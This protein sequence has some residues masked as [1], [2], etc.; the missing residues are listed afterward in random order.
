SNTATT[1][2]RSLPVCTARPRSPISSRIAAWVCGSCSPISGFRC[3]L[4]RS[5]TVRSYTSRASA[6]SEEKVAVT[7]AVS[8]C[9]PAAPNP[10][11]QPAHV[12]AFTDVRASRKPGPAHLPAGDDERRKG[13]P[14]T[15][16]LRSRVENQVGCAAAIGLRQRRTGL[17]DVEPRIRG[18]LAA[19]PDVDVVLY[20]VQTG[21]RP[22]IGNCSTASHS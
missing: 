7:D 5:R 1:D 11:A 19:V 15:G 17:V 2:D 18:A 13:W 12:P 14:G 21:S 8:P 10:S 6:S 3:R 4:R 20:L 22:R 9:R 16:K